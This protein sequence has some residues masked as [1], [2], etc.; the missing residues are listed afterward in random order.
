MPPKQT[1][2]ASGSSAAAAAAVLPAGSSSGTAAAAAEAGPS[3][4]SA[5]SA[6]ASTSAAALV[7][8]S[9]FTSKPPPKKRARIASTAP[10]P[11]RAPKAPKATKPTKKAASTTTPAASTSTAAA[12]SASSASATA[13]QIP[14]RI[15]TLAEKSPEHCRSVTEATEVARYLEAK[16]R[17]H[18]S[19][20]PPEMMLKHVH[21]AKSHTSFRRRTR[22]SIPKTDAGAM[23][24]DKDD[25]FADALTSDDEGEEDQ[26]E[27]QGGAAALLMLGQP[28]VHRDEYGRTAVKA[29]NLT[30][31]LAMRKDYN[32]EKKRLL[33]KTLAFWQRVEILGARPLES[34]VKV[35]QHSLELA[36][37]FSLPQEGL[38]ILLKAFLGLHAALPRAKQGIPQGLHSSWDSFSKLIKSYQ[39]H[40]GSNST[41]FANLPQ[42]HFD[43]LRTLAETGSHLGVMR[44]HFH[45]HIKERADK[46]FRVPSSYSYAISSSQDEEVTW[47]IFVGATQAFNVFLVDQMA[48]LLGADI[49]TRY[50]RATQHKDG[51]AQKELAVSST[52]FNPNV[53]ALVTPAMLM[54]GISSLYDPFLS[55]FKAVVRE[56]YHEVT[57]RSTNLTTYNKFPALSGPDW[58]T[59]TAAERKI[60][61]VHVLER[62]EI[63]EIDL[64]TLLVHMEQNEMRSSA[65][66]TEEDW[67]SGIA[68]SVE[69]HRC[70]REKVGAS[71]V[72]QEKLLAQARPMLG[73]AGMRG[74]NVEGG[75]GGDPGPAGGG[76]SGTGADVIMSMP[77]PSA[78]VIP[79]LS[80]L[81]PD[82]REQMFDPEGR[83]ADTLDMARCL[84]RL[85]RYRFLELSRI[86]KPCFEAASFHA[87]TIPNRIKALSSTLG[88][89]FRKGYYATD[90]QIAECACRFWEV[91]MCT[92]DLLASALERLTGP[93]Y[94][95]VDEVSDLEKFLV[96]AERGQREWSDQ[97]ALT[98]EV[99]RL[100]LKIANWMVELRALCANEVLVPWLSRVNWKLEQ[101]DLWRPQGTVVPQD[102]ATEWTALK[103]TTK[104]DWVCG[105]RTE[106]ETAAAAAAASSS[107]TTAKRELTE[108]Q[109]QTISYFRHMYLVRLTDATSSW[110]LRLAG[111]EWANKLRT[112]TP[113][114]RTKAGAQ[115]EALKRVKADIKLAHGRDGW[116]VSARR[117]E[118]VVGALRA[119]FHSW[120]AGVENGARLAAARSGSGSGSGSGDGDGDGNGDED[121]DEDEDEDMDNLAPPALGP[122]SS[123]N[124][125]NSS[126]SSSNLKLPMLSFIPQE[127]SDAMR[128]VYRTVQIV[129]PAESERRARVGGL[130]LAFRVLID[131]V[132]L[133][134]LNDVPCS[135]A[136][137]SGVQARAASGSGVGEGASESTSTAAAITDSPSAYTA[138]AQAARKQ[139]SIQR[140][141]QMAKERDIKLTRLPR[142][143]KAWKMHFIAW[144]DF[145]PEELKYVTTGSGQTPEPYTNEI[146]KM[147]SLRPTNDTGLSPGSSSTSA[148]TA[149]STEGPFGVPGPS[150]AGSVSTRASTK[151]GLPIRAA[152]TEYGYGDLAITYRERVFWMEVVRATLGGSAVQLAREPGE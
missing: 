58:M 135:A 137:G 74:K 11:P 37:N 101:M 120:R 62:I 32:K 38:A 127:S 60:R 65:H 13:L 12:A 144:H 72:V 132:A 86:G 39:S 69:H 150:P 108:E 40:F 104:I 81:N 79:I 80:H 115:L 133:E 85:V 20:G 131:A 83:V 34:A 95:D 134:K 116:Q 67:L 3:S 87:H 17:A 94:V 145:R 99:A 15:A 109:H 77:G 113:F 152:D 129:Y 130:A 21:G 7:T 105:A 124:N 70:L 98:T 64:K 128:S 121:E 27:A 111:F 57:V 96:E 9:P 102:I 35:A 76:E 48:G 92:L 5:A 142:A 49:S 90:E 18:T 43:F 117:A 59:F 122:S 63:M 66:R 28:S 44:T 126:S 93:E 8:A 136:S 89:D 1:R 42:T 55:D 54:K 125:N 68:M 84:T 123:S 46:I 47:K 110:A 107:S 114:S 61:F 2:R 26:D 6:S 148:S 36:I 41:I 53:K 56:S 52:A 75:G 119:R 50:R 31:L 141:K 147:L 73:I 45:E 151:R 106:G 118:T 23:D 4:T 91:T 140:E 100:R 88:K 149:P 138:A 71:K 16:L 30:E 82:V 33:E 112:T 146:R 10:K 29:N 14:S 25:E 78:V 19:H 24:E 103:K 51:P 143:G 22:G 139:A 97:A